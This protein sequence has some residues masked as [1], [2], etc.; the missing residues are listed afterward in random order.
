MAS[1]SEFRGVFAATL[2]PFTTDGALDEPLLADHLRRVAAIPGLRGVL[3]NGHAGEN[4]LLAPAEARLVVETAVAV[5]QPRGGLV[6]AGVLGESTSMAVAFARDAAAAGADAIAVFP[7]FSWALAADAERV[8]AH[9]ESI[10]RAVDL[11]IVLYVTSVGAGGM[12]YGLDVLERLLRIES[13]V[14]IKEGSWNTIT[15]EQ[16]RELANRVAPHV[17]VLA[18]GDEVLYPSFVL[19]TEGSM[20]S[21]ACVAGPHI[22]AL[23]DAV[24]AGDH[25][26]AMA[27]HRQLQPIANFVYGRTPSSSAAA[28]L[29]AALVLMGQ[30]PASTARLP[31]CSISAQEAAELKQLL[32]RSGILGE[33]L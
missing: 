23:L 22:V 3:C 28:R 18:S 24:H 5:V 1:E 33:A 11:P 32:R 14:A 7:P 20:V 19:G 12:H 29:K 4:H 6:V 21:L 15:Y 27:L 2:T 31:S 17:A 13:V 8:V 10:A 26:R 9:H 25:P 30:W 16:T